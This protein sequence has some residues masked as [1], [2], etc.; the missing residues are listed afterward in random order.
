MTN[1][2]NYKE[3]YYIIRDNNIFIK[4]DLFRKMDDYTDL[5]THIITIT[6]ECLKLREEKKQNK[7]FKIMVDLK[8]VKLKNADYDFIKMLIPFLEEAYP[9][10][11][12]KM[13]FHNTPF[14]FKTAYSVIRHFIHKETRQ[15]IIF[16]KKKKNNTLKDQPSNDNG[17]A[18]ANGNDIEIS[19]D[20]MD[21]LF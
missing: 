13:Y 21:E 4:A 19:E 3:F 7:F 9:N 8:N 14:I 5:L 18:N 2:I 20:K 6:N 11:L 16:V 1:I 12:E 15:K 17:N 10:N